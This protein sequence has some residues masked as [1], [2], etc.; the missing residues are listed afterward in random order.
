MTITTRSLAAL[1]CAAALA[2]PAAAAAQAST[3]YDYFT[4]HAASSAAPHQLSQADREYY[5]AVF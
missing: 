2:L 4:A 5:G 1:A 3:T